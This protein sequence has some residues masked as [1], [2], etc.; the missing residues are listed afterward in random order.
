MEQKVFW[1]KSYYEFKF[2]KIVQTVCRRKYNFDMIPKW[3]QIFKL[4]K[5]LERSWHL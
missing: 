3:S 2:F 5:N 1:V 4:V